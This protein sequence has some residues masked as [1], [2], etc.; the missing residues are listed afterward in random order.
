MVAFQVLHSPSIQQWHYLDIHLHLLYSFASFLPLS[1]H[2]TTIA[3]VNEQEKSTDLANLFSFP[4][5]I[6]NRGL[7]PEG[8]VRFFI[9]LNYLKDY[10]FTMSLSCQKLMEI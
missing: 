5:D 2:A 4:V 7:T 9:V 8:R 3:I 6:C 1:I 10:L